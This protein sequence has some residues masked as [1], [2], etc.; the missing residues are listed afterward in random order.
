MVELVTA[1]EQCSHRWF[2]AIDHAFRHGDLELLPLAV[3]DRNREAG[4]LLPSAGRLDSH[5]QA[6]HHP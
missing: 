5:Q 3:D 1:N 6:H 4:S 2:E